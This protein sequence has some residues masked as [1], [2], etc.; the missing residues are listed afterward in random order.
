MQREAFE[1]A[2]GYVKPGGRILYAT[3]SILDAENKD[4]TALFGRDKNLIP[5][6]TLKL[7]PGAQ[8]DGFF[9]TMFRTVG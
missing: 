7:L 5:E 9:A 4:Q 3:C 6:G 8:S 2:R 1:A